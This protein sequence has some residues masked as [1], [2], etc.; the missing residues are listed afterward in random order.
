MMWFGAEPAFSPSAP[1]CHLIGGAACYA[2]IRFD[3]SY[4]EATMDAPSGVFTLIQ[5]RGDWFWRL[6]I[7]NDD[8]LIGPFMS[9]DEAEKDARETLGIQE[10]EG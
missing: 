1:A 4:S 3:N 6:D 2:A 7:N 5:L 8:G 10:G 9:R